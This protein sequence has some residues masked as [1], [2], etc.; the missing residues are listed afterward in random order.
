M[1]F[2]IDEIKKNEKIGDQQFIYDHIRQW[3]VDILD[4]ILQRLKQISYMKNNEQIKYVVTVLIGK[5][6]KEID[7]G[8]HTALSCLW[9]GTTDGCLTVKWENKSVFSIISVF[10][11]TL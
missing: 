4:E 5:K 9:N 8:L 6:K 10:G 2:N 7:F 1:S 11:L 3:N